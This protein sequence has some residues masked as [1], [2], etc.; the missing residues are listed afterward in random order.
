MRASDCNLVWLWSDPYIWIALAN[1]HFC[2]SKLGPSKCCSLKLTNWLYCLL[3]MPKKSSGRVIG[4][5]IIIIHYF[6]VPPQLVGVASLHSVLFIFQNNFRFGVRHLPPSSS[7]AHF[8]D[9]FI[10]L[11]FRRLYNSNFDWLFSPVAFVRRANFV[12]VCA[13][14]LPRKRFQLN[15]KNRKRKSSVIVWIPVCIWNAFNIPT[16][17]M[18]AAPGGR[19]GRY[20]IVVLHAIRSIHR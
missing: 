17:I 19:R 13:T 8:T 12:R 4:T 2:R 10:I 18:S 16:R 6:L 5:V 1:Q 11:W 20:S 15:Y 3:L 7:M 9:L 14:A